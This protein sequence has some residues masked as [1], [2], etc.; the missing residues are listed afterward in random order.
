MHTLATHGNRNKPVKRTHIHRLTAY[1]DVAA[2]GSDTQK[3]NK[4]FKRTD[5]PQA[6]DIQG[7][8]RRCAQ[9]CGTP[10]RRPGQGGSTRGPAS[11]GV[12]PCA[13][14]QTIPPCC[15]YNHKQGGKQ[16]VSEMVTACVRYCGD[17]YFPPSFPSQ[18]FLHA[19]E[20]VLELFHALLHERLLYVA[21][22]E[23]STARD[24]P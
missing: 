3:L 18:S 19:D 2:H 1:R 14:A 4:S 11:A 10:G 20:P 12:L 21:C 22:T 15:L 7:C 17:P 24:L 8:P 5:I 9:T 23:K 6:S 16:G 13:A